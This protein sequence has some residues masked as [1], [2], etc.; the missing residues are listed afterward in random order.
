MEVKVVLG[1]SLAQLIGAIIW[2]YC[3]KLR[4]KKLQE[5]YKKD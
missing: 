1:L 3:L 2:V 4:D 5:L